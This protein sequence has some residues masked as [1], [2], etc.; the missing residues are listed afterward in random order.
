MF[1]FPIQDPKG[2]CDGSF[3]ER[4]YFFCAD[5]HGIF[6]PAS[7][8]HLTK[9]KQASSKVPR[10]EVVLPLVIS[11]SGQEFCKDDKV[12]VFDKNGKRISGKVKWANRRQNIEDHIIG[13]ETDVR[14]FKLLCTCMCLLSFENSVLQCISVYNG[15]LCLSVSHNE[16][17]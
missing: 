7:H 11:K 10:G 12:F 13:I 5:N 3:M 2:T 17:I 15:F 4:R 9:S 1:L 6:L 8:L 16:S 14:T